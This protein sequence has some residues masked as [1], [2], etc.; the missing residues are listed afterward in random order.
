MQRIGATVLAFLFAWGLVSPVHSAAPKVSLV[1]SADGVTIAYEVIGE[2]GTPLVLVHGWSC[3]RTYWKEQVAE[4]ASRHRLVLIDL[5]GHGESGLGRKEYTMAAFGADVA[6]VVE[7]LKLEDVVLVGHSMGADVA[8]EAARRLPGRVQRLIWVDQ[9]ESFESPHTEAAVEGFVARFRNDFRDATDKFV[10]GMFGPGADPRLIDRIAGDM[11]SAPAAVGVSALRQTLLNGAR[12]PAAL[13]EL[14]LPVVAINADRE[15]TDETSLARH[16]VK[17]IVVPR[18]GHF[19][20]LEDPTRFNRALR[21][22][23]GEE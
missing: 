10:R 14:R 8:V 16:G 9:Y 15:P 2:R 22:A 18:I 21:V 1:P 7:R 5:A 19:V 4:F 6:A 12:I 3:D 11:A 13:R 20:Q 17:A 23:L